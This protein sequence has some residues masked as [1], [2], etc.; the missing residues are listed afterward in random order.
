MVHG[1]AGQE[2]FLLL[3]QIHTCNADHGGPFGLEHNITA[4]LLSRGFIGRSKRTEETVKMH[5]VLLT[6]LRGSLQLG[7][8]CLVMCTFCI[9]D[10]K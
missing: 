6:D 2:S 9:P 1:A 8:L 10:Y 7:S 3:A 4:A 5:R